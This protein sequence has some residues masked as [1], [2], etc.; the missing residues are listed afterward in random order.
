MRIAEMGVARW[1]FQ[2]ACGSM[3][4][5]CMR[6]SCMSMLLVNDAFLSTELLVKKIFRQQYMPWISG[7]VREDIKV[8]S[9]RCLR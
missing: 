9:V 5:L 3:Y 7:L 8:P 6:C 2:A 4:G 1:L